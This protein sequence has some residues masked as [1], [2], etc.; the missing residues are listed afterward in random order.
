MTID[1]FGPAAEKIPVAYES[2]YDAR[3]RGAV[4]DRAEQRRD[5]GQGP[6]TTRGTDAVPQ[7]KQIAERRV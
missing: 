1:V 7:A 3:G 6:R 2:P 5:Q 4:H